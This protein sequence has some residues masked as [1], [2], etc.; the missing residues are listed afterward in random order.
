MA[1][2]N[3]GSDKVNQGT[4]PSTDVDVHGNVDDDPEKLEPTALP[5][6]PKRRQPFTAVWIVIACGFALLSDGFFSCETN[7]W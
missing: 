2:T 6:P 1:T 5:G 4:V 3:A 7:L